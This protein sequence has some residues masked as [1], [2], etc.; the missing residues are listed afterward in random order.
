MRECDIDWCELAREQAQRKF[1]EPLP[2]AF[3]EK[4]KVQRFLLSRLFT[5]RYSE[6]WRNFAG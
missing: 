4:V 6:I 3:A 1:G 5:G 2:V